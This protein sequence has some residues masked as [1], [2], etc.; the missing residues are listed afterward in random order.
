MEGRP[1][2][3]GEALPGDKPAVVVLAY[4]RCPMLC[5]LVLQG[6]VAGL[7]G[8]GLRLGQDYRVLTV[9]FDPRDTPGA[10]R[11]K[12]ESV[13]AGLGGAASDPRA[14]P[15][16]VGA[17]PSIR[18][19]AGELGIRYAY[20][21][22]TDQYAHPAAA[23][24]LTKEGRISRYLYGV[25]YAPRDLRLALVEAGQGR[26][27]TIVDRVLLTCYR[28]DPASRRY[29]PFVVGFLRIGGALILATVILLVATLFWRGRSAS[30]SV[31]HG[32]SRALKTALPPPKPPG[33]AP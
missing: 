14:W 19:L 23:V 13:L 6:L 32:G 33:G 15:F 5:G 31:D 1:V 8:V 27:G 26:T 11:R 29:G 18:A 3:V 25:E 30:T 9:S 21:P 22:R 17:E 24:V 12:R 28:Y 10:A 4:Y 2:T 7:K 20:D 16:V